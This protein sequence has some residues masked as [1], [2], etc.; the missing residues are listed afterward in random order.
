MAI[1]YP[2]P[3]ELRYFYT[4]T[5]SSIALVHQQNLSLT[6]TTDP[7]PGTPFG[8]LLANRRNATTVDLATT[9]TAWAAAAA[10]MYPTAGATWDYV[11]L[12]HY[13]PESFDAEFIS[14]LNLAQAGLSGSAVQLASQSISTF[15]T[16]EG[17]IFKL[18]FMETVI[19]PAAR[20]SAPYGHTGLEAIRSDIVDGDTYP[21]IGR[22]TSFPFA[23]IAHFP[24]QNEA[25]FKARFR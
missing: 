7:A 17:G 2:G 1:N 14:S 21:W 6:L 11:E 12:W 15:R 3:Y 4:V 13:E 22:D 16:V 10:S 19:V 20:D 23:S 8:G 5:A 24:G 25:V 18:S 9:A